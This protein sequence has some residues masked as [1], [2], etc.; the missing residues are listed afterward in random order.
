MC[1]FLVLFMLLQTRTPQK[2]VH[3]WQRT[4]LKGENKSFGGE[5]VILRG[6]GR[7]THTGLGTKEIFVPL[8]PRLSQSQRSGNVFVRVYLSS[9]VKTMFS[10]SGFAHV[11]VSD[12]RKPKSQLKLFYPRSNLHLWIRSHSVAR[13]SILGSCALSRTRS[14]THRDAF[15][16]R[17]LE[18]FLAAHITE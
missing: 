8:S 12:S 14:R 7:D 10:I 9:S 18:C 11:L 3:R 1:A 17:I 4:V 5:Q 16:R 13:T 15:S 2:R 6:P